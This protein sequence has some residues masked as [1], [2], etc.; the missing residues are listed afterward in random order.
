M[1]AS[2][3]MQHKSRST[4]VDNKWLSGRCP[5]VAPAVAASCAVKNKREHP[6]VDIRMIVFL[7]VGGIQCYPMTPSVVFILLSNIP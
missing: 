3:L 2:L 6:L 4:N 7:Q 5:Q 1:I